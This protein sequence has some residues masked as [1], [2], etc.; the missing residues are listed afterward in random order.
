MRNK[1]PRWSLIIIYCDGENRECVKTPPLDLNRW[2]NLFSSVGF[3]WSRHH[4]TLEVFTAHLHGQREFNLTFG[5]LIAISD[6]LFSEMLKTTK[7]V[8]FFVFVACF[9]V[10]LFFFFFVVFCCCMYVCMH[11][12]MCVCYVYICCVC[13]CMLCCVWCVCCVCCVCC[14]YVYVCVYMCVCVLIVIYYYWGFRY[15]KKNAVFS[16]HINMNMKFKNINP[17]P[18]K[19][20]K[21]HV[22]PLLKFN[23]END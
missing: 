17:P 4:N 21:Q 3:G 1:S 10:C 9:F 22:F 5:L 2:L 13:M 7:I 6:F 12:C 19:K 20:K 14:V 18:K 15:L 11:G 8:I 16:F 23:T